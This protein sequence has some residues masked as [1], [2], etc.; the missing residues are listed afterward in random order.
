MMS[1]SVSVLSKKVNDRLTRRAVGRYNQTDVYLAIVERI[2]N[3][4]GTLASQM[5]V[6]KSQERR[7]SFEYLTS[8]AIRDIGDR[9]MRVPDSDDWLRRTAE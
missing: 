8:Q 7:V 3:E 4:N 6:C 5:V 1:I 2:G 9:W